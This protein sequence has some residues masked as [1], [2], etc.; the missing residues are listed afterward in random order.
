MMTTST[1]LI[2]TPWS[3]VS[4]LAATV[5][6]IIGALTVAVAFAGCSAIQLGYNTLPEMSYWWLDGYLDFDDAQ[7]DRVREDI[8]AL[9]AWHRANELP[10]YVTILQRVERLVPADTTPEQLCALEPEVRG[11][12]LAVRN[13]LEPAATA[14]AMVLTGAQLQH[15]QRKYEQRN[16]EYTKDW[17]KLSREAQLDKRAKEW[18]DRAGTLYGSL[19]DR[20]RT[21]VRQQMERSVLDPALILR[22]RQRRQQDT[23]GVLRRITTAGTPIADSRAAMQSLFDRMLDSPDP[24]FRAY[25]EA[26]R[27]E[28]CRMA[29]AIHNTTSASQREFAARRLRGWQRDLSELAARR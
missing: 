23:L 3:L 9:H 2:S 10:Q 28:T 19:D 11:R 8:A 18:I 5:A 1:A 14:Q 21:L 27:Q 29:A 7:R 26:S 6:R 15:L 4:R 12:L 20:Q 25:V 13:R 22:E 17:V 16:R 24:A